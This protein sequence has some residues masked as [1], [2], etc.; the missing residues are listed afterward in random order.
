MI[1]AL[2]RSKHNIQYTAHGVLALREVFRGVA[3]LARVFFYRIV[4]PAVKPLVSVCAWC[5]SFD[6]TDPANFQISHD[7]CDSCSRRI[8]AEMDALEAQAV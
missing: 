6:R 7:L 4:G 5:P 2:L 8:N 1:A 3:R